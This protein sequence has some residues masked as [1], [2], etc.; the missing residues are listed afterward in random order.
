MRKS[1]FLTATPHG[2]AIL[3]NAGD[4][5]A[6]GGSC[7]SGPD[8]KWVVEPVIGEEKL[9]IATLEHKQIREERQNLTQQDLMADLMLH[10]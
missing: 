6:K 9:I 8:G 1:D 5:L 2:S 3:E 7:I 4:T 10:S